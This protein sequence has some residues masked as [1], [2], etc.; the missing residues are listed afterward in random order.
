M[1][2]N[3]I[4][5]VDLTN[6]NLVISCKFLLKTPVVEQIVDLVDR[7]GG[8]EFSVMILTCWYFL[9]RVQSEVLPL[10]FGTLDEASVLSAGEAI[11]GAH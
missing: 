11:F 4:L 6:V 10:E 1:L 5:K 7:L 8:E 3:G 2:T 9:T